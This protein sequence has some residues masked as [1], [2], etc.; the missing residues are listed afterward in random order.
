MIYE[1][2]TYDLQPHSVP[3]VVK[4]FGEGY[5]SRKQY[6]QLAA[7]WYTEIGPLNQI[8]HVWPYADAGERSRVRAESSK[9]PNWPPKI[10]EF[11][12][13][14]ESEIFTPLPFTPEIPS[15]DHGP[16]FEYRSYI[17]KPGAIGG[18][19]ERWSEALEAR[20]KLSPLLVALHSDVGALNKFVHIWPYEN[21][22]HRREVRAE[23]V[24]SGVWPPKGGAGTLV[25]QDSKIVLAVPFSPLQ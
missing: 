6:S 3:E 8:I 10:G 20:T 1:I 12:V 19:V 5:Q 4:R 13:R 7:F 16:I 2:R 14:M 25:S 17:L 23:A 18:I 11:A 21:L 22:E 24:S 15:G 9:D